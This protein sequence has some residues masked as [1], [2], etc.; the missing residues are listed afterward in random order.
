MASKPRKS[1]GPMHSQAQ[2]RFLFASHK[3][4]ARKWANEVVAER[5]KKTGYRSLPNRKAMKKR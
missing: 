1:P 3:P 2:W 5:G 4:F